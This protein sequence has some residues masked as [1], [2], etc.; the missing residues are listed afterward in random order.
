M[1]QR[2]KL[3]REA[4]AVEPNDRW[5]RFRQPDLSS[6]TVFTTG[7][8]N[9]DEQM[10]AEA[11]DQVPLTVAVDEVTRS[12]KLKSKSKTKGDGVSA[13]ALS[14]FDTRGE[15]LTGHEHG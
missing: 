7:L 12:E 14:G 3:W 10:Q 13:R 4:K 5:R 8:H 15:I 1:G 2:G 11:F 6:R 9:Q